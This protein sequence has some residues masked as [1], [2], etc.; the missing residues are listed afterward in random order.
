MLGVMPDSL[1]PLTVVTGTEELLIERSVRAMVSSIGGLEEVE[2]EQL[3]AAG[4]DAG[5][6]TI[7]TSPSLFGGPPVVVIRGIERLV[8]SD[9]D[10][11]V[12]LAE[13]LG[14]LSRPSLDACVVLVHGGG[15]GGKAVLAAAKKAGAVTE[16][17]P[18]PK[19]GGEVRNHRQLFVKEE[20]RARRPSTS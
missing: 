14:Y 4:L 13:V 12:P 2:V 15:N 7:A 11:E 9:P 10:L 6:L 20:F 18:S 19:K 16:A 1:T 5:Q 17:T 3:E 8:Q